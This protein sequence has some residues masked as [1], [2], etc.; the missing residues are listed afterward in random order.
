MPGNTSGA[1]RQTNK[2]TGPAVP[3]AFLEKSIFEHFFEKNMWGSGILRHFEI[4]FLF[5]ILTINFN[6][7]I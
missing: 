4:N 5:L 7:S 2:Q 1:D 3:L 6:L